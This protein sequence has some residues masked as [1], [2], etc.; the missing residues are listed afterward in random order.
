MNIISFLR[1][2][3][4]SFAVNV[5][6]DITR[7]TTNIIEWII[8]IFYSYSK[9]FKQFSV[10]MYLEIFS[11]P[12]YMF[13]GENEQM[14]MSKQNLLKWYHPRILHSE[15]LLQVIIF[16]N[17][18]RKEIRMKRKYLKNKRAGEKLNERKWVWSCYHISA[19]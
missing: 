8:N 1:N 4:R 6:Q 7:A 15:I 10:G 2:S 17:C 16:F 14:N 3:G 13:W 9:K 5:L 19:L 11:R 18:G 12:I